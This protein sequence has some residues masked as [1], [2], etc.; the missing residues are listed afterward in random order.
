M[1]RQLL[2]A[3]F[4]VQCGMYFNE[5]IKFDSFEVFSSNV[6][7]DGFWNYAYEYP[8]VNKEKFTSLIPKIEYYFSQI[9][10]PSSIYLIDT[11]PGFSEKLGLLIELGYKE[12]SH[13]SF[14]V[15][16]RKKTRHV[17]NLKLNFV[18]TDQEKSD[19]LTVFL[20][21]YGGDVS[22]NQPYGELPEEYISALISAMN[23][24]KFNYAFLNNNEGSTVSVGSLCIDGKYGGLYNLGTTPE[25]RG[26]GFAS[27]LTLM[28]IEWFYS[29]I[30]GVLFLQT[31]A[32]TNVEKLYRRLGFHTAFE[33]YIMSKE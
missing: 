16:Q 4:A 26:F 25:M 21:A 19:F 1:N 29:Q 5:C 7:H 30:G 20:S 12:I 2:E 9:N 24:P 32:G 15:C 17:S 6:I 10:C 31:E 18:S 8:D 22:P 23:N 11:D 3:H 13:E 14:M 33:G 27:E 28:L